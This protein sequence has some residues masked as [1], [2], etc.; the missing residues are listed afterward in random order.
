MKKPLSRMLEIFSGRDRSEKTNPIEDRYCACGALKP[1]VARQEAE[2]SLN[3]QG[4]MP[5]RS[6]NAGWADSAT[7]GPPSGLSNK[8]Y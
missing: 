4:H 2:P 6:A 5:G 8:Q 7:Y 1:E 3:A